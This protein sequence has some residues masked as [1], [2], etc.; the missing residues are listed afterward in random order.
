MF[1]RNLFIALALC[2]ICIFALQ[3]IS[4]HA[5]EEDEVYFDAYER[6]DGYLFAHMGTWPAYGN[7]TFEIFISYYN[8]AGQLL[9]DKL[10]RKRSTDYFKIKVNPPSNAGRAR[11]SFISNGVRVGSE[12]VYLNN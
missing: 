9:D 1:K 7:K 5:A 4:A 12:W 10:Y 11:V 8:D 6:K 3:P 2:L